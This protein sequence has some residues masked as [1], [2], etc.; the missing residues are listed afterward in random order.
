MAVKE[1]IVPSPDKVYDILRD[2]CGEKAVT[3]GLFVVS[4]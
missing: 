1:N 2:A 4:E 3:I